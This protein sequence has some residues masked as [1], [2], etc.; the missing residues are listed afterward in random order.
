M[1]LS[2]TGVG[3]LR[4]RCWY[5]LF[6]VPPALVKFSNALLIVSLEKVLFFDW[7]H[8]IHCSFIEHSPIAE[9]IYI[10]YSLLLLDSEIVLQ[11]RDDVRTRVFVTSLMNFSNSIPVPMIE[12]IFLSKEKRQLSHC[13]MHHGV[14]WRTSFVV[15]TPI[16]PLDACEPGV[17]IDFLFFRWTQLISWKMT[18]AHTEA[19][20]LFTKATHATL[21]RVIV[22]CS[23]LFS[24]YVALYLL[25]FF[26]RVHVV[27]HVFVKFK[28]SN[29]VDL[30]LIRSLGS[31]S[32]VVA[33]MEKGKDCGV[34]IRLRWKYWWKQVCIVWTSLRPNWSLWASKSIER[35]LKHF[36]LLF[37]SEL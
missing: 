37:A 3:L 2:W 8:H 18:I 15:S 36:E 17:D 6:T 19:C 27:G 7:L 33:V 10:V 14:L 28:R 29:E 24:L 26:L 22:F 13:T 4:A 31:K 25:I 23:Y 12:L 32:I 20:V 35:C 16:F 9:G 34:F 11:C 5:A 30:C 1:L 21:I